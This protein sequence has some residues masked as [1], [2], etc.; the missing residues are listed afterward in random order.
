MARSNLWALIC[1]Q[2]QTPNHSKL[3]RIKIIIAITKA[4]VKIYKVTAQ[5]ITRALS[6]TKQFADKE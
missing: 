6:T 5:N 4:E 3:I 2:T 1:H